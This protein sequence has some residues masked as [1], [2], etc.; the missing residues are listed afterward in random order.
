MMMNYSTKKMEFKRVI[1]IFI[2]GGEG[3]HWDILFGVLVENS[4]KG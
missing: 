3:Q 1:K 4:E 2:F